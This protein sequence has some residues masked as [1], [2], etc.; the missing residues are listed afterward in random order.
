MNNIK[1]EVFKGFLLG[2]L[3]SIIGVI[4]CTYLLSFTK[5]A[6]FIDTFNMFKNGGHLWMLLALGSIPMLG[7]FF[8][9]LRRDQEYRARGVVFAT[10]IVAFIAFGFYLL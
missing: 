3:T 2:A 7:T 1:K 9:L 10:L 5:E 6:T 4:G 8:L